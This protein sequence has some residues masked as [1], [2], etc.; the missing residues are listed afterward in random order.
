MLQSCVA[1]DSSI[2]QGDILLSGR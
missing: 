1:E 2:L